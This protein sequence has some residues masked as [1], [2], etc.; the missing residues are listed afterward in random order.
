MGAPSPRISHAAVWTGNRMI[1]WGGSDASP[2]LNT[3]GRYDP[4]ADTWLTTS[5]TD[6]PS[7]R[8]KHTA[9]WTG[10]RRIIWGGSSSQFTSYLNTGGVYNPVTDGWSPTSF[11]AAT[12]SGRV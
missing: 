9:I 11:P 8:V 2:E 10:S 5:L 7:S 1:V 6:A 3:G 12:F 4:D